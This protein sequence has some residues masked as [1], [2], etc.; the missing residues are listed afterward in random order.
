MTQVSACH[1]CCFDRPQRLP[2]PSLWGAC[3]RA[4]ERREG[5]RSARHCRYASPNVAL[6]PLSTA[7]PSAGASIR[8]QLCLAPGTRGPPG[9]SSALMTRACRALPRATQPWAGWVWSGSLLAPRLAVL[10]PAPPRSSLRASAGRG[11][12]GARAADVRAFDG[13]KQAQAALVSDERCGQTPPNAVCAGVHGE[14][15]RPQQQVHGV[16]DGKMAQGAAACASGLKAPPPLCSRLSRPPAARPRAPPRP[17]RAAPS[18]GARA[19]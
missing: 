13:S 12:P 14:A 10:G 3:M 4:V 19:P 17:C 5:P 2:R 9:S 15:G 16:L 1:S 6:S 11:A 8:P 7:R 18:L